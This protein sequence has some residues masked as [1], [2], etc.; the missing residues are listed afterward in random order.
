MKYENI[1]VVKN[2]IPYSKVIDLVDF[3]VN[4]SYG[5]D[6]MYHE[7][8]RDYAETAAIVTMYTDCDVTEHSFDDIMKLRNSEKW[9]NIT[10]E[11]GEVYEAFSYYVNKE[12]LYRNVPLRYADGLVKVLIATVSNF[13]EII[14]KIDVDAL[15]NYD[16]SKIMDAIGSLENTAEQEKTEK[17]NKTSAT[18]KTKAKPDLKVVK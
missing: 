8:L 14:K 4:N 15:A 10:K 7:Y 2:D 11:L 13:N 16:F 18:R 12:I 6:G 3:T 1:N 9:K 17:A 5:Q